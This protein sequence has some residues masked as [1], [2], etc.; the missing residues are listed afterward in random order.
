MRVVQRGGADAMIA[1]AAESKITPLNLLRFSL[2]GR[3]SRRNDE[4][5]RA[6][7]PFDRDRDGL[8]IGEGA[9][10]VILEEYDHAR[11]RGARIYGEVAGYGTAASAAPPASCEP[12]VEAV[13][14]AIEGALKDAD[15]TAH[16]IDTVFAGA[17]GLPRDDRI[18]SQ[19]IST[20]FSD[21]ACAGVKVT[22]T[23]S[24]I[25]Q[26]GAPS[27]ALDLV[28][29]LLAIRDSCAPPTLNCENPDPGCPVDVVRETGVEMPI[30]QALVVSMSVAGQC[31]AMVLRAT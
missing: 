4:P 3:V 2:L 18:E 5:E 26:T 27:G 8:V 16:E 10:I 22:S 30:R 14:L 29:A 19:G 23:K 24:M 25:G 11:A 1:G 6:S 20:D 28:A 15:V 12:D 31:A 21:G 7:R 9:G 13:R 17:C